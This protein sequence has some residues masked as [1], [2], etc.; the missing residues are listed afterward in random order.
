MDAR[1]VSVARVA[2][3]SIDLQIKECYNSN[4]PTNSLREKSIAV[5]VARLTI[6][7]RTC[8]NNLCNNYSNKPWQNMLLCDNLSKK[9]CC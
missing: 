3:N 2:S 6:K 8:C 1:N 7:S 4:R 9:N 5:P